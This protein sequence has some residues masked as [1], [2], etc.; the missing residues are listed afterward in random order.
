MKKLFSLI[1][2]LMLSLCGMAAET[3][4]TMAEAYHI[5]PYAEAP[6]QV[7][8]SA[9]I[10]LIMKNRSAIATWQCTLELP[11]GVTFN[12]V[13]LPVGIDNRYPEGYNAQLTQTMNGEGN[14]ITFACQGE[15]GYALT[16]T[17]GVV[18]VVTVDIA[19]TVQPGDYDVYVK[20]IVLIQPDE[21]IHSYGIDRKM[22]WTIEPA[23]TGT[24][25][26]D[27]AGG[28]PAVIPSITQG[29]GTSVV[30]PANPTKEGY[31]FAGW[32]PPIPATMPEGE[33][34]CVAQWTINSYDVIYVVDGEEYNRF[35]YQYGAEVTP[36]AEPTKE[37]YTFSGWSEIPATMPAGN[38]TVTGSFTINSYDVIYV[39]D[40]EEYQRTTYQYGAEVTPL[41]EPTKEGYT[42]SGWS[43]IPVTMPANDVTVT[44][45][46]AINSYDVIYVVDGEEYNR[47]TYQYGAEVTPLAEPTKEGYTFSGWS[48]IPATMP[49]NDVTVT[50]SFAIN[51]YDVIYVVDGEEYQRTTYQ[52]GAEV[53]PLAEPTKEGYTFSGWSEIPSTMPANDV[54]VTGS[55]SANV[56][57]LIYIVDGE[58]YQRFSYEYGAEITPLEEPT[59][60][61][62]TFSGW[63]DIP[64]TMPDED[65]TVTG[66]FVAVVEFITLTQQYI[67]FSCAKTLDFTNSDLKAYIVT[68]YIASINYA[69]LE[70]VQVVPAGTG[71][72]LIGE[73]GTTYKIPYVDAETPAL[74]GNMLVGVVQ[75]ATIAVQ[76]AA[77]TDY[78]FNA[79]VNG[80]EPQTANF[81]MPSQSA[82]L[83]LPTDQVVAGAIVRF[84]VHDTSDGITGLK[85][86]ADENAI[87]D[88]QGRRVSKAGKGIYIIG[89]KKVLH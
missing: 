27:T 30:A 32:N 76:D 47:F 3:E 28:E 15:E 62:Y 14:V 42:F 29:I 26:F 37:G 59:K 88:L 10:L 68:S 40:G 48:E 19:Q 43:E 74:Q 4:N 58:E 87:F 70:E 11:Q 17:D 51:S 83:Q 33:T 80:F 64:A 5:Y 55:F 86:N 69:V 49:A 22:T 23:P 24:I 82:Y 36:L 21:K 44:G 25:N 60:D 45:S 66:T 61:G 54:T 71:V 85:Q 79:E 35:T 41:A 12:S 67:P 53:T 34:T 63:S 89:G 73:V 84:A 31:T 8:S 38:V 7:G 46:F 81:D 1:T 72:M 18:A 9:E 78:V 13:S 39:V 6:G 77:L 16:G 52:Y 65:V 50:G 57:T 2:L 75:A 20:N 56:H